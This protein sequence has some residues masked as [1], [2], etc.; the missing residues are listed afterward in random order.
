M[1]SLVIGIMPDLVLLNSDIEARN[2]LL[3]CLN[4]SLY[5]VQEITYNE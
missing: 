2:K 4:S 3:T 5:I 1:H